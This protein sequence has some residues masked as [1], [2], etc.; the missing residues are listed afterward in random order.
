MIRPYITS[1]DLVAR[2]SKYLEYCQDSTAIKLT[3]ATV[4][5][6]TLTDAA[7][8]FTTAHIGKTVCVRGK[9]YALIAAVTLAGE[10][11]SSTT[12][13][14]DTEVGNG[15]GLTVVVGA[16]SAQERDAFELLKV[17]MLEGYSIIVD[18]KLK[19]ILVGLREVAG[20]YGYTEREDPDWHALVPDASQL[21][22][23]AHRWACMYQLMWDQSV[24]GGERWKTMAS[25]QFDRYVSHL[26]AAINTF[27][28]QLIAGGT[29]NDLQQPER[30][31]F[32]PLNRV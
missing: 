31:Q 30:M 1:Y 2:Y 23:E 15:T 12:C 7:A 22:T 27:A 16:G 18:D 14:L 21:F 29:L 28:R 11:T 24:Q 17:H 25:E 3:A 8:A 20:K 9:G 13:T 10:A 4:S 26:S 5:G 19:P 6:T 32:V